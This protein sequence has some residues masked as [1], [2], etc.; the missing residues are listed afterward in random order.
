VESDKGGKPKEKLVNVIIHY[1]STSRAELLTDA[2]RILGAV[3]LPDAKIRL[4]GHETAQRFEWESA[5]GK[6]TLSN[7]LET[8][9]KKI[10]TNWE[11][12][13]SLSR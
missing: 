8:N 6:A 10:G 11:L 3:G 9:I 4:L 2:M 7:L 1:S 5:H 13:A 12:Y